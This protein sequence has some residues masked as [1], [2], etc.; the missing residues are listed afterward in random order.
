MSRKLSDDPKLSGCKLPEEGSLARQLRPA[1][2]QQLLRQ[3][4]ADPVL[5]SGVNLT[6]Q[7][8]LIS[9]GAERPRLKQSV[10]HNPR[11]FHTSLLAERRLLFW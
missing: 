8:K 4:S 10:R 1:P 11:L 2:K 6:R 3:L 9:R 5:P 7:T